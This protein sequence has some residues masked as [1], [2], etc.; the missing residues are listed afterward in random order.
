MKRSDV[1]AYLHILPDV[2]KPRKALSMCLQTSS[3]AMD[4]AKYVVTQYV[5]NNG[6]MM[7][8]YLKSAGSVLYKGQAMSDSLLKEEF[9]SHRLF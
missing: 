9:R 4:V 6:P 5:S 1:I 3:E 2:L 8:Q 7:P